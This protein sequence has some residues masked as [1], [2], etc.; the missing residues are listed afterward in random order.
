M[1]WRLL[2]RALVVVVAVVAPLVVFGPLAIYIGN[3]RDLS[4][5]L[6]EILPWLAIGFTGFSV[7]L[8]AAVLACGEGLLV[9]LT[10]LAVCFYL[11][12]NLLLWNYGSFDGTDIPWGQFAGRGRIDLAVW[13]TVALLSLLCAKRL[14]KGAAVLCAVLLLMQL[15]NVVAMLIQRPPAPRAALER[16]RSSGLF[17]LSPEQNVVMI[18]LDEFQSGAMRVL[19]EREPRYREA[20]RGFT[21]YADALAAYPTTDASVPSMLG[22]F[23]I[24]SGE[25]LSHYF[26]AVKERGLPAHVRSWGFRTEMVVHPP[27]RALCSEG[28][29]DRC[30]TTPEMV[31]GGRE[32]S[33]G[34]TLQLLDYSLFRHVPHALKR[35]VYNDQAWTLQRAN[36]VA[37]QQRNAIELISRFVAEAG[38]TSTSPTFTFMHLLLPHS[39]YRLSAECGVAERGVPG[40]SVKEFYLDNVRCTLSL[41]ERLLER[42]REIGVFENTVV[43]LAGDHGGFFDFGREADFLPLK[44]RAFPLLMIKPPLERGVVYPPLQISQAPAS[45]LDIPA[46]VADLVGKELSSQ[47]QSLRGLAEESRRSRP[48]TLYR[49]KQRFWARDLLPAGELFSVQGPA[50]ER[51]SWSV[52]SSLEGTT[53]PPVGGM[54]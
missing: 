22:G 11:Q 44:T 51:S 48:F 5:G 13:C 20:F 14:L 39:P 32:T 54:P 2:R 43:V 42:L 47:G 36:L 53:Q 10:A 29:A 24:N 30:V 15:G 41:I 38:N 25:P 50:Y 1:S 17:N 35:I 8:T 40:S 37:P 7:M 27:F 46:T 26:S 23:T 19:L 9:P 52:A 49:W 16:E 12:G 6:V 31:S 21:F 28:G 45:L 3:S 33:I 4:S 18:V 34:E